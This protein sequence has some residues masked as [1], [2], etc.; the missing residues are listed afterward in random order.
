M[1]PTIYLFR[2]GQTEF[3]AERRLQ[4]RIDSPLTP[5]GRHQ[6][7]RYGEMLRGRIDPSDLAIFASP[8]GR[9]R[10]T[11]DLLMTA[12]GL[13]DEVLFDDRLMELS[14][15]QWE[16]LTI[17]D[18]DA[19]WPGALDG[20]DRNEWLF[21]SPGGETYEDVVQRV[22]PALAQIEACGAATCLIVSHGVTGRVLRGV[23]GS[24]PRETAI[25]L[26]TPQDA[27]FR[28]TPEG[29]ERISCDERA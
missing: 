27:F 2:H 24:L 22:T 11:T 17:E 16:G 29:C 5:L 23:H 20:L 1:S 4:G 25:R 9:V 3:N 7:R 26:E 21:M 15:G 6:A 8:L 19:L 14:L 13:A 18:I 10:E 12:A 28:L